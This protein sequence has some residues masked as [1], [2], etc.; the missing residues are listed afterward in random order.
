MKIEP[1]RIS[2]E[3]LQGATLE[4]LAHKY[5]ISSTGVRAILKRAGVELRKPGRK[6]LEER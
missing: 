3:Y 6:R 2:K 1:K 5:Q 4:D